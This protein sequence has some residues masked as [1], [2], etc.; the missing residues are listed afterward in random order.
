MT[1][2]HTMA[3]QI[4]ELIACADLWTKDEDCT[5]SH[6]TFPPTLLSL[7]RAAPDVTDA[8]EALL[9]K[10]GHVCGIE[11]ERRALITALTKTTPARNLIC[12]CCGART[13][14]RQWHNRDTGYGVCAPCV[15]WQAG[16]GVSAEE[17]RRNYGDRGV[18]YDIKE[19]S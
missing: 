18:H 1:A 8:A 17:L 6:V 5:D 7:V 15:D 9:E 13:H 11:T 2:Q 19:A 10:I 16:R 4:E 14:G 12:A 3:S